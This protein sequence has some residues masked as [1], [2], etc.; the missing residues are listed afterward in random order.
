MPTPFAGPFKLEM[1]DGTVMQFDNIFVPQQ[2]SHRYATGGTK[3]MRLTDDASGVRIFTQNLTV[4]PTT[5]AYIKP[6]K[7]IAVTGDFFTLPCT[8]AYLPQ[9]KDRERGRATAMAHI[10][11]ADNNTS[12]KIKKPFIFVEGVDFGTEIVKDPQTN[13]TIRTGD[14]G[15]DIFVQGISEKEQD[16]VPDSWQDIMSNS[17]AFI[18]DMIR[19]GF[20]VILVDFDDGADYIQKNGSMLANLLDIINQEKREAGSC[21]SNIVIGASMGG[22]VVRYALCKM[23]RE[24]RNHD[25]KMYL[26]FD[27]PHN[28]ANIPLCVQAFAWLLEEKVLTEVDQLN[29]SVH[30]YD[31]N[32]S[33]MKE[34]LKSK[35]GSMTQSLRYTLNSNDSPLPNFWSAKL[36]R[37]AA[38][39]MLVH[40]FN[41][42]NAP[43]G[44][45]FSCSL[46]ELWKQELATIGFP[47]QA[48]NVGAANGSPFGRDQGFSNGALIFDYGLG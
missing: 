27:S 38:Q 31:P 16:A 39:Q 19:D 15:W 20:D 6:D 47:K 1:G 48:V 21:E 34:W 32:G 23:E 3:I 36:N 28:G 5:N 18:S 2:F 41:Q 7:S 17:P 22:Q 46:R 11:F 29:M 43:N 33:K 45:A 40:H 42:I 8:D 37:P 44:N 4:R 30:E 35:L 25:T 10:R 26:S 24:A 9:A 13:V 12:G 14:F